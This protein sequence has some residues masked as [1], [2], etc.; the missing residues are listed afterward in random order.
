M[1]SFLTLRDTIQATWNDAQ[2]SSS[3]QGS[4]TVTAKDI[5][6][7]SQLEIMNVDQYICEATAKDVDL[8]IEIT[9]EK[10]L[11]M[12]L[13]KFSKRKRLTSEQLLLMRHLLL[14]VALHTK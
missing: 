8:A 13:A 9:V 6:V 7:P 10:G 3:Y 5:T 11:D 12:F 14:F 2:K 4:K 1:L